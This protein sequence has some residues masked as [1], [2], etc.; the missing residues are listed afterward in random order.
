[1]VLP[2]NHPF[3]FGCSKVTMDFIPSPRGSEATDSWRNGGFHPFQTG[4]GDGNPIFQPIGSSNL[5]Y[6]E[7]VCMYI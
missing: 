4:D 3:C 5:G 1:M 7:Y 6:N 2:P